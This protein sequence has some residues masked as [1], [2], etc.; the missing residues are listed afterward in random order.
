[1]TRIRERRLN[2]KDQIRRYLPY[3]NQQTVTIILVV[4]TLAAMAVAGGAPVC[5]G[6]SCG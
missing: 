5:T 3:V 6:G 1:M 2:V 4:L